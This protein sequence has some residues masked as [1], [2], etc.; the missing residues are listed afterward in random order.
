MVDADEG[1]SIGEVFCGATIGHWKSEDV[2]CTLFL[3]KRRNEQCAA[4]RKEFLGGN[5]GQSLCGCPFFALLSGAAKFAQYSCKISSVSSH[6]RDVNKKCRVATLLLTTQ[7]NANI[8]IL[9]D[10]DKLKGLFFF[11]TRRRG[12]DWQDC[13]ANR[14]RNIG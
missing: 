6:S 9:P 1:P 10:N 7:Q 5:G 13:K 3:T 11:Y 2:T 12:P 4:E 14:V 8:V